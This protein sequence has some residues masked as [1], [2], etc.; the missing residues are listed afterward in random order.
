MT[1]TPLCDPTELDRRLEEFEA[2]QRRDGEADL[3]RFLPTADHADYPTVL[4][5]LVRVDLEYGWSRGRPAPIDA[6]FA[7]F[8]ALAADEEGRRLV[9][10]EEYR[11]RREAGESPDPAE[12]VQRFGVHPLGSDSSYL[13]SAQPSDTP[14]ASAK[15]PSSPRTPDTF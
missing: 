4:R 3:A 6:Y 13:P 14:S 11:Q 10:F 7:R 15:A 9:V 8:P 12:Y 5:E 2:A 1:P